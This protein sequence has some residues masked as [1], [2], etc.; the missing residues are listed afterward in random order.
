MEMTMM[1][2]AIAADTLRHSRHN[3]H[4]LNA[5]SGSNRYGIMCLVLYAMNLLDYIFTV[6][7][8]YWLGFGTEVEGNAVMQSSFVASPLLVLFI[9]VFVVGAFILLLYKTSPKYRLAR[10][11][12]VG[13]FT[14][15]ALLTVYHFAI[16]A[17]TLTGIL[18][19]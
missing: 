17:M 1:N 13:L 6:R 11:G 12:I 9:K 16:I 2:D 18:V 5:L 3:N 7:L 10:A 15:Y 14:A 19:P 4:G 8:I